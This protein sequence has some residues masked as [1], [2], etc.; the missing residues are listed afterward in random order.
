MAK[1]LIVGGGF[2]GLM[3]AYFLTK[4]GVTVEIHEKS[5]RW[6]GLIRTDQLTYGAA[7]WAANGFLSSALLE[8]VA[9]NISVKLVPAGEKYKNRYIFFGS[10]RRWPLSFFESIETG[11]K[12]LWNWLKGSLP[13]RDQESLSSWGARTLGS[14]FAVKVLEAAVLGIYALSPR[15]LSAKLVVGRFFDSSQKKKNGRF[16]GTVA[17]ASGMEEWIQ[18]LVRF[19]QT[20]GAGLHLNSEVKILNQNQIAVIATHVKDLSSIQGL[21][22]AKMLSSAA[23][24]GILTCN[25][26]LSE[27]ADHLHGFGI[28]FHPEEKMNSLGCLFESDNFPRRF[29]CRSE[30]FIF[31]ENNHSDLFAYPD[32]R[33]VQMA[34]ADRERFL[35]KQELLDFQVFRIPQG[36]PAYDLSLEKI[37][38]DTPLQMGSLYLIGNFTGS[39]GLGQIAEKSSQLAETIANRLRSSNG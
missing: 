20:Q 9:E 5:G 19:L 2:S 37:L 30:R 21:E 4:K 15:L 25:L 31:S 24:P 17:P 3:T 10:P 26:F 11:F 7:E 29:Q 28:L 22:F 35:P 39:L 13:P 1:V 23:T 14:A 16:K 34:L 27:R 32:H 12:F 36:Y 8:G 33:I 6:G 18:G 38:L